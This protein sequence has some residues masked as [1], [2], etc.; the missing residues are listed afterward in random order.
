M[1]STTASF[2]S[3][4]LWGASSSGPSAGVLTTAGFLVFAALTVSHPVEIV[5][6]PT[7]I[8][9]PLAHVRFFRLGRDR[10]EDL[11]RS[12]ARE[13]DRSFRPYEGPDEPP[14]FEPEDFP[15]R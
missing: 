15:V 10:G 4:R 5:G 6:A 14:G 3:L 13:F 11:V 1:S 12:Y 8:T 9:P 7:I 2:G